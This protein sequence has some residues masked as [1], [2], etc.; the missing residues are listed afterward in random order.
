VAAGTCEPTRFSFDAVIVLDYNSRSETYDLVRS[1][2]NDPL[3][4]G[5]KSEAERYR[6]EDRIVAQPWTV[7]QRRLILAEPR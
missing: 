3:T 2:R 4:R 7:R 5:P 6:P 1:L